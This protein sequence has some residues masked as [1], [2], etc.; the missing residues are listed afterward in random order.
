MCSAYLHINRQAA[1]LGEHT[2]ISRCCDHSAFVLFRWPPLLYILQ[3]T[4]RETQA[5]LMSAWGSYLEI[6]RGEWVEWEEVVRLEQQVSVWPDFG[7]FILKA[8]IS[9]SFF[10]SANKAMVKQRHCFIIAIVM[11]CLSAMCKVIFHFSCVNYDA[12][13]LDSD[14]E[15]TPSQKAK[16]PPPTMTQARARTHTQLSL[17][18]QLYCETSW[19]RIDWWVASWPSVCCCCCDFI[20]GLIPI[21]QLLLSLVPFALFPVSCAMLALARE[22]SLW[23]HSAKRC[24]A[25]R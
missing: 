11:F 5:A 10:L 15:D 22:E 1:A 9:G 17:Y 4:H 2:T 16:Q 23:R 18:I 8:L 13:N 19:Q 14:R 25:N 7:L 6:P 3:T 21:C 24:Q 20:A 12:I